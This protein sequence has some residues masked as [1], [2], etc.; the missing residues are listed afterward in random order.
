MKLA[1]LPL[2]QVCLAFFL[3]IWSGFID[4]ELSFYSIVVF[5]LSSFSL[6][7]V[8][9]IAIK[10]WYGLKSF[11]GGVA[12]MFLFS[13]GF[14][15]TQAHLPQHQKMH[16]SKF[17]DA[18]SS[19]SVV[20]SFE[21]DI[22]SSL[23]PNA[24]K[25]KYELNLTSL[26]GK[27]TKGKALFQVPISQESKVKANSKIIGYG[28][29]A[30]FEDP[31]NPQQF[32]YK[33]YMASQQMTHKIDADSSQFKIENQAKFNLAQIG[34]SIR[35]KI[36]NSLEAHSFSDD[37]MDIIQALLL[38]QKQ[39]VDPETYAQFSKAGVVHILAVSGLHVGII[40]LIL[41]SLTQVLLRVR[42]GKYFREFL[43][44]LGIW[45]FAILAGMT[46]SV[47]RAA[48]MFSFLSIG[49][50]YKRKTSAVNTLALSAV[51]LLCINPFLIQQ[52]GFQLSY[53]AV[54][55]I[56]SLQPRL[57][58]LYQPKYI[59]DKRLWDIVTV[60]LTAQL[61]VLPLSLYYFHQFP[62]LFLLSNLVI[63]PGLGLILSGGILVILLSLFNL[64][65]E[66]LVKSYGIILDVLLYFVEWIASKETLIFSN[67]YFSKSLLISSLILLFSLILWHSKRKML[68]Y[69][70]LN[71]SL[72]ALLMIIYLTNQKRFQQEETLVFNAYR[73]SYLGMLKGS[74]LNLYTDDSRSKDT[75]K[76]TYLIKNYALL[77]GVDSINIL[78]FR[79]FYQLAS[80][81]TLVVLDSIPVMPK[82]KFVADYLYLKNSPDVNLEQVLNTLKPKVIIADGSNYK[83]DVDV[84]QATAEKFSIKFH[85][86]WES[87]A[88]VF[89]KD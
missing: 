19:E 9:Y 20:V 87:G 24:Y 17:L 40:L 54:L 46:P 18:D 70:I 85:S 55:S 63:L 2:L 4:I 10:G 28:K 84:W 56:I 48:V 5:C 75:I 86:T 51:L 32:N 47:M 16:Y 76:S 50:Q 61:G 58:T 73:S 59:I 64:L 1:N 82:G 69:S 53:L 12:L 33:A 42:H 21:G 67:L 30:A 88:F 29:I 11:F 44:L 6:F 52:V 65:P 68:S 57:Y 35:V 13:L 81:E 43:V 34:E 31:K 22:T 7:L 77:K 38:G 41:R 8:V 62:G 60:T 78:S 26:N 71:L 83:S 3:G 89:P 14:L 49:L 72:A 23:K 36:Q 79:N 27:K 74:F 80:A 15:N 66:I 39:N 45:G 25:D 37:Q